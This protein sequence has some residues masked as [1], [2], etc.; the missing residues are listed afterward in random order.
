MLNTIKI[1]FLLLVFSINFNLSLASTIIK[2]GD[3]DNGRVWDKQGSPYILQEDVYLPD[4]FTLY[5]DEGVTIMSASSS[6][7]KTLTIDGNLKINGTRDNPVIIDSLREI[8]LS[9]SEVNIQNAI[10][11]R[12]SISIWQSTTS[13]SNSIIK[14]NS[15]GIKVMGSK[16]DISTSKLI[17]NNIGLVSYPILDIPVLVLLKPKIAHADN[18]DRDWRH[19]SIYIFN[20][21]I[22]GNKNY[23]IQ[24][25][26]N[27]IIEAS[28]NWW[29]SATGPRR[30]NVGEGDKITDLINFDPWK[31]K[32]P[33][34][35]NL[36]C[37]NVIF[38]PGIEASRLYSGSNTLWEP[39]RNI[40]VVKLYLNEKGQSIN[41]SVYTKDIIDLAFGNKFN[42][43]KVYKSFI[44][45]MN[46]VVAENYINS[47]LPFP[48]D[49]RMSV[50]DI[51]YGNT[52][53]ATTT[54]SLIDSVIK[55]SNNSKNGKVT[56][57][58]HS[59][60][61]LVTKMLS[62]ALD[63]M[64]KLDLIDQVITVGTPELGTSLAIPAILHGYQQS[65]LNGF[66]VSESVARNLS[67]NSLGALGL[68]PSKTFFD[69]N[70]F[71]LIIDNYSIKQRSINNYNGF[72]DF[73]INN[74]FSKA[75]T[76]DTSIPIVLNKNLLQ[77]VESIHSS[78]DNWHFPSTTRLTK[79]LG[80]G[81][82]T[83]RALYYE[84]DKHCKNKDKS[85]CKIDY[86]TILSSSGDGTVL[87][88]SAND[89][90]LATFIN[91]KKINNS[92]KDNIEHFN[93]L[94]SN[95]ILGEIKNKIINSEY[96]INYG[97]YFSK[98]EPVDN[99]KWLTIKIYS[100]I[101]IHLYDNLGRHTGIIHDSDPSK[102]KFHYE[103]NIPLSYY[104]D[105]GNVKMVSVPFD[106]DYEIV[107]EGSGNGVFTL[108]AEVSQHNQIIG[109]TSFEEIPVT[110]SLNAEL[111]ISSSTLNFASSTQL[112]ID[113]DGDGVTEYMHN[114]G[115]FKKKINKITS[116]NRK[117]RRYTTVD[118]PKRF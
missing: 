92:T 52:K 61:G 12:T 83:T 79:L 54:V 35:I 7:A 44:A 85:K 21:T 28:N 49:W 18:N 8:Y 97:D 88:S 29:G 71:D 64:G 69:K 27:N 76:S 34:K 118:S 93:L 72:I 99:D 84:R 90:N 108:D 25:L 48:Y 78:I 94:E 75:T 16:V 55:L 36:C 103:K 65:I 1:S 4:N 14:N 56:I 15:I 67:K 59:N 95:E 43:A 19:N 101:D 117:E 109:T 104:A 66:L 45:M 91:L 5:I 10:L 82:P 53:L 68:L 86:N 57:I 81:L 17:D 80:W 46:G 9:G 22:S 74:N 50:E 40:D 3:L 47:W 73:L 33:D 106:K 60:G 58:A 105:F 107:L 32:D 26:S 77:K 23:G 24:N 113:S 31:T 70:S 20:S 87:T 38:I 114:K 41:S 115:P 42:I 112:L 30:L 110:P 96:N 37:S 13:I 6:E 89:L 100:P 11:D 51:V 102:G 63:D 62:K 39:N 98:T 111:L 116:K 2:S